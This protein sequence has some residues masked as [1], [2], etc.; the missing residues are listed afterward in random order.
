MAKELGA[1]FRNIFVMNGQSPESETVE[2]LKRELG[3]I[4][5][6]R[7]SLEA[8]VQM[9]RELREL[10]QGEYEAIKQ[11]REKYEEGPVDVNSK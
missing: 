11:M 8:E 7:K 5:Q 9:A 6:I 4:S 2:V 10:I 3:A 1:V